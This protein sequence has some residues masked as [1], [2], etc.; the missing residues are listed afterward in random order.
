[1]LAT[2][3]CS[4]AWAPTLRPLTPLRATLRMMAE[5]ELDPRGFVV[6][7]VGDVVKVPSKWPGEWDVAQ[8]DFV[9]FVSSRQAYEVDLLP[10]KS[11]GQS[12]YRL[13]GR[14]PAATR[15]DV[16]KLS[17]I[18]AEYVRENDAYRINEADLAP[19]GG[20][21]VA[22]PSMTE[23][24]LQEYAELKATLLREAAL[25]GGAGAI[26]VSFAYGS[27]VGSAAAAGAV[28]GCAYLYLLSRQTDKVGGDAPTSKVEAYAVAGRLG[29]PVLLMVALSARN[30]VSG[31]GP[32]ATLSMLTPQQFGGAVAGFLAYKVP[33]L[34]RQ[35]GRAI[36]ELSQ[37]DEG[38]TLPTGGGLGM[39][40]RVASQRAAAKQETADAGAAAA[41]TTAGAPPRTIVISGP[42]GVGKSTLVAKLLEELPEAVD[43]S[44]SDAPQPPPPSTSPPPP[45]PPSVCWALKPPRPDPTPGE[46]HDAAA[47]ARRG[48][49]RRLQL[50]HGGRL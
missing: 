23:Q 43:F 46:L 10:L 17:R 30:G 12:L 8:V 20:K 31:I 37:P 33:L 26:G 44:A 50:S 19:L 29:V 4:A 47:E 18:A 48:R 49:R 25:V 35:F 11:V 42:S 40:M 27:E 7:Q 41:A 21:K 15:A 13:P 2:L 28:A 1:M 32:A 34:A 3:I 6:P 24:G 38:D 39:A 5:R 22:D 14:K 36:A 45:P 9:Q 16:A